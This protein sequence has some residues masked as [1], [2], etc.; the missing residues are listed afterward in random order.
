MTDILEVDSENVESFGDSTIDDIQPLCENSL[1]IGMWTNEKVHPYNLREKWCY[2]G[3]RWGS[4]LN[5][6]NLIYTDD[7]EFPPDVINCACNHPIVENCFISIPMDDPSNE[8]L[9]DHEIHTVTRKSDGRID[10]IVVVGN[11]CM[12]RCMEKSGR[13]C[14]KCSKPHQ[15]RKD[16]L[17]NDCRYGVCFCCSNKVKKHF[18]R[19]KRCIY[20]TRCTFCQD[21]ISIYQKQCSM[22]KFKVVPK[23]NIC[24]DDYFIDKEPVIYSKSHPC[25]KLNNRFGVG[26]I[27]NHDDLDPQQIQELET[28]TPTNA[29]MGLVGDF[30]F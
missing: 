26:T 29:S 27:Y 1:E 4:R 7:S 30:V 19:C 11:C 3:G 28:I 16:N 13:T 24:S 20:K 10:R 12:Y 2:S 8:K 23:Y 5:Y 17:C 21:V 15:N 9:P 25:E 22:C 6:F 18:T 14:E